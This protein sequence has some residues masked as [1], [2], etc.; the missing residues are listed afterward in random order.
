MKNVSFTLDGD[1]IFEGAIKENNTWNGWLQPYVTREVFEQVFATCIAPNAHDPEFM[2][3]FG[4]QPPS[5]DDEPNADG[6][7]YLAWGF[8]FEEA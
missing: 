5:L 8:C 7:Y 6:L 4:D 2:E 3:Y 1:F